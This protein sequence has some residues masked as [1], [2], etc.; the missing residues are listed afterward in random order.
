MSKQKEQ[1]SLN[2]YEYIYG[3]LT[4]IMFISIYAYTKESG[5]PFS[6][7]YIIMEKLLIYVIGPLLIV[8]NI[9]LVMFNKSYFVPI[10]IILARYIANL[11]SLLIVSE[12]NNNGWVYF[13]PYS[14]FLLAMAILGLYWCKKSELYNLLTRPFVARISIVFILLNMMF[15]FIF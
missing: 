14:L 12:I 15:Y 6:A 10:Y 8:Q 9:I 7:R 1:H 3:F 5:L 13:I 2:I 4:T 11:N